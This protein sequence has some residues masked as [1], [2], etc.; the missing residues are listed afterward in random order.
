MRNYIFGVEVGF[1]KHS[2]LLQIGLDEEQVRMLY[3]ETYHGNEIEGEID[4]F[5]TTAQEWEDM[6]DTLTD[7]MLDNLVFGDYLETTVQDD[8]KRWV[9]Y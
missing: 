1:G 8:L 7:L 4:E 6:T 9:S 5:I 3:R 2:A